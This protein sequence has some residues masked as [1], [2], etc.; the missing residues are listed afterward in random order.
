MNS[1]TAQL[2]PKTRIELIRTIRIESRLYNVIRSFVESSLKTNHPWRVGYEEQDAYVWIKEGKWVLKV[3]KNTQYAE[4]DKPLPVIGIYKI[5]TSQI[6]VV[7]TL[8]S[9][10]AFLN[11]IILRDAGIAV[12]YNDLAF[13]KDAPIAFIASVPFARPITVREIIHTLFEYVEIP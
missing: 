4:Y 7:A 6:P 12:L 10:R 9:R 13:T 3:Y 2:K 5:K 8:Q 11:F 1:N